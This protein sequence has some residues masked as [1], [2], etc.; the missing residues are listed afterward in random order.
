[1]AATGRTI[2]QRCRFNP[3]CGVSQVDNQH[4][5][6]KGYRDLSQEEIDLMNEAKAKAEEVGALVEKLQGTA[7]IDQRW[8]SIAKT[9]LQKGFMSLIRGIAQPTTF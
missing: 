7:G 2:A 5:K 6:I 9:D 8:V 4:Q 3:H 1:M